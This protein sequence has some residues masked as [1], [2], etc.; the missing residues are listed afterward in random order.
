M[1]VR[2]ILSAEG[3]RSLRRILAEEGLRTA[4]FEDLW[5]LFIKTHPKL[6][7]RAQ[8][9]R[10]R[11]QES[12]VRA[13]GKWVLRE[14]PGAKVPPENTP[15]EREIAA[16]FNDFQELGVF[17]SSESR[18]RPT[19][20]STNRKV[21]MKALSRSDNLAD[22][23]LLTAYHNKW[24]QDTYEDTYRS[25]AEYNTKLYE[26]RKGQNWQ[27]EQMKPS[28]RS[29]DQLQEKLLTI[30]SS[31]RGER[32]RDPGSQFSRDPDLT[33]I[34]RS[35]KEFP[36]GGK[37]FQDMEDGA[38]HWN[39]SQLFQEGGA[40]GIGI[41][42]AYNPFSGWIQHTWAL[43]GRKVVETTPSNQGAL[44]YYGIALRG[45]K[46]RAFADW[47]EKNPPGG[48]KVRMISSR[49]AV[50]DFEEEVPEPEEPGASAN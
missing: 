2:R 49:V 34:L 8:S 22:L 11:D 1:G 44:A 50:F 20:P 18:K 27:G 40:D 17:L 42:Y 10:K 21:S 47:T 19:K 16:H 45:G 29:V 7:M 35:G 32:I 6:K 30:H 48:G 14:F 5:K 15:L 37:E 46:A 43:K 38:C 23:A 3:L 13:L 33:E 41:G 4:A 9:G 24:R 36:A 39:A 31:R 12:V 25:I 28:T 26:E